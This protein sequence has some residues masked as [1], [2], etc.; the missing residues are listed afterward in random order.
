[1]AAKIIGA[2]AVLI[3][4]LD[5]AAAQYYRSHNFRPSMSGTRPFTCR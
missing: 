5:D 4:A 2:R 3:H 1:L